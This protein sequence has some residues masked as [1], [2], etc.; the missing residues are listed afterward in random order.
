[1]SATRGESREQLERIRRG[2]QQAFA[3]LFTLH[4]DRLRQMVIVRLDPRL[5]GRADADDILQEAYLDAQDR[6]SHFSSVQAGSF[7]IWLRLIVSQTLA[8]VHRRHLGAQ[9]R[10]AGRD[11]SLHGGSRGSASTTSL[12]Q[13][14][15]GHLTSPSQAAMRDELVERIEHALALLE[16]TD[17]EVL[18][19]RHFEQL[20]NNDVAEELG[21]QV[22]AASIRYV[23]ALRR[24]KAR[25]TQWPEYR[26]A[27]LREED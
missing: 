20:T 2:D 25:L 24:L 14:L 27:A 1:M 11:V 23:R 18:V 17:R 16:P 6:M 8:N 4:R 3:E 13:R 19:L 22:K 12:A 9:M 10:D 5:A 26:D 7:F 21:I 15:L